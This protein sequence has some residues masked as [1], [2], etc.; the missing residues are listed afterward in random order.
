[1]TTPKEGRMEKA[2]KPKT[3]R[4]SADAPIADTSKASTNPRSAPAEGESRT[5]PP[6]ARVIKASPVKGTV[7]RA[8]ARAAARRASGKS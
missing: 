1:M 7:S 5:P 3:V 6:N 4:K 2:A 8:A